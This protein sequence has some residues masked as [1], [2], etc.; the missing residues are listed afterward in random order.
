M[1]LGRDVL[2]ATCGWLPGGFG[3]TETTHIDTGADACAPASRRGLPAVTQSRP[4]EVPAHG[5]DTN[6]VTQSR[7][8]EV[9]ARGRD[10]DRSATES[11]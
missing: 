10:T 9:P 11:T 6:R 2:L 8:G 7:P 4:G 3:A 5:R 1:T